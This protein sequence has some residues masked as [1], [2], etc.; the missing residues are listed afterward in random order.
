MD[1]P[2]ANIP[3]ALR[4]FLARGGPAQHAEMHTEHS[5]YNHH[6]ATSSATTLQNPPSTRLSTA[7]STGNLRSGSTLGNW[8]SK[9]HLRPG[10]PRAGHKGT[11]SRA[12]AG[13]SQA[14]I[15]TD[16]ALSAYIT[17]VETREGVAGAAG[18][19]R[20][21]SL[22]MGRK[23]FLVYRILVTGHTGQWWVARRYSEFHELYQQLRRQFP[24]R[25]HLWGEFPSK[26]L[27]PGLS[28]S[29]DSVMQRRERLNAFLRALIQDPE[30]TAH[31][32]TQQF[33]RDDPLDV[34]SVP[35]AERA[36]VEREATRRT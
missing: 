23:R 3:T 18:E 14:S 31:V 29:A 9:Y 36:A 4:H 11:L 19:M 33:L 24:Q 15:S 5:A 28:S 20:V 34:D 10:G 25:T 6:S 8:L 17:S 13:H 32:A 7:K 30:I 21:S 22:R 16:H 35:L 26:R 12:H 1:T 2:N 27:L